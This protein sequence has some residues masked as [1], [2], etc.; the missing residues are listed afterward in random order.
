MK[1]FAGNTRSKV[2]AYG[3]KM[4][5][6][7]KSPIINYIVEN[8]KFSTNDGNMK[9]RVY[10][11]Y[12]K[13]FEDID[14]NYKI[15]LKLSSL[16]FDINLMD[17]LMDRYRVKSIPIIIDAED[18]DNYQKYREITNRLIYKYNHKEANIIK[19]YQMYRKDSIDELKDD[20][21]FM[22][23]NNKILCPKIVRGAYYNAEKQEG[24]L[25]TNKEDTDLS[26]SNALF[27]CYNAN[28]PY[29]I[30]ATHNIESLH[31]AEHLNKDK[32]FSLAHLMGMNEKYMD[33]FKIHNKVYTYIPYGPYNEMIPYLTRRLYE[34]IDSV[35]YIFK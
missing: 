14:S 15:A 32:I 22:A 34:N 25:F 2:L 4:L 16:D 1:Y 19:T 13:L 23:K 20:L 28:N 31:L 8:N 29:N 18:N 35:K 21:K 26:Y 3:K 12:S 9:Y 11:E 6:I 33:N 30:V 24:H 27:E 7:N 5:K 17:K 10:N